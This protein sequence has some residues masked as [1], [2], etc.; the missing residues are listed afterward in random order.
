[1]LILLLTWNG[2]KNELSYLRLNY[3]YFQISEKIRNIFF[4]PYQSCYMKISNYYKLSGIFIVMF[5][6]STVQQ[7]IKFSFRISADATCT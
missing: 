3:L 7:S 4:I 2:A 5:D 1:M 6:N